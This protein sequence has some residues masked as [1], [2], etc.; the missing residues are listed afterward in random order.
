MPSPR[1]F[2]LIRTND[3]WLRASHENTALEGEMVGLYWANEDADSN[4]NQEAFPELGAGLAFD[5]RCRLYH[6]VAKEGEGQ[7]ERLLWEIHDPLLPGSGQTTPVDLFETEMDEEVG[8]FVLTGPTHAQPLA[9][10]GLAVDEDDRLFIAESGANRILIYDL[11]SNRL[12]RR[13]ALAAQPTDLVALGRAVY[14]MLAS[15]LISPPTLIKLDTRSD[16]KT[17]KLSPDIVGRSRLATSPAGELYILDRTGTA[18]ARILKYNLQSGDT[19]ELRQIRF[20]TDIEFQTGDLIAGRDCKEPNH[21]LVVARRPGEDFFRFCVGESDLAELPP[22]KARGYDGLGIVLTPDGRIGFWTMLGFRHAVA[23]RLRYLPSG[24]ITTFQLDSQEFHTAWGRLFLDACIPTDT[25]IIVRCVTADEPPVEPEMVHS[26]PQNTNAI[27]PHKSP[28]LPP[29][30][31]AQLLETAPE[32]FLHRR[33]TGRELPWVRMAETDQFETYEAPVLAGPGRYLWVRIELTGNTRKTPRVK[34]LRAEYPTH[35]YL[36]RIPKVFS[37]DDR[38]ASFLQRYLATFE[39]MLGELEAKADARATLLD[40]RSAPP[41]MLPWLASFL[42]L[43]LDGRMARAPRVGGLT[44]DVRRT[45]I[46]EVTWLFRF[47]G[48][49]G[50]L[51]RFVDIYLGTYPGSQPTGDELPCTCCSHSKQVSSGAIIIEKFRTRG[52][53]GAILGDSDGLTSTSI[54]GAGY[55]VGGALA[56]N[57]QQWLDGSTADSF[58][59]HAHRFALIIPASLTSEQL[60]VVRGILELHRPA[61]TLVEVCTVGAGMRV[62]RG[63]HVELTSIIGRS[64]GFTQLQLGSGLLGRGSIL[65]RPVAGTRIGGSLIGGDSRVG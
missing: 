61:H 25:E 37:R 45:L 5:E 39:G 23:A 50:G 59:T 24:T 63:L 32:Q 15:T 4:T 30:S 46:A 55:R 41:E 58:A 40:P 48:T 64:A 1:P 44:E 29:V 33:E 14:A 42:G 8:D 18:Q 22:L 26:P 20:A 7:I 21:V 56:Q 10:L 49:I 31:L 2:A 12:L 11:I 13:V 54:L 53:G 35:D 47:R 52:L 16:P 65:G 3:Q 57:E 62:G 51:L 17:L 60:D 19:T 27:P 28:P 36:R 38:V 34:S 43:V 6:S 9:P